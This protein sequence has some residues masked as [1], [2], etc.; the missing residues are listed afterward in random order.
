M[1]AGPPGLRAQRRRV[2]FSSTRRV[3]GDDQARGGRSS[4]SASRRARSCVGAGSGHGSTTN[5]AGATAVAHSMSR[6]GRS[7]SSAGGGSGAAGRQCGELGSE[8]H[9]TASPPPPPLPPSQLISG[10]FS[11]ASSASEIVGASRE[12]CAVKHASAVSTATSAPSQIALDE[13]PAVMAICVRILQSASPPKQLALQSNAKSPRT[14]S[15]REA[16][17][18]TRLGPTERAEDAR[19]TPSEVSSTRQGPSARPEA[20]DRDN[21]DK[22]APES[23]NSTCWAP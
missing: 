18:N 22:E 16:S 15:G 11:A 21:G 6:S 14:I 19:K 2:L 20:A 8:H 4:R 10:A 3:P 7:P 23:Q 1:R 5:A 12:A 9:I 13:M 17:M